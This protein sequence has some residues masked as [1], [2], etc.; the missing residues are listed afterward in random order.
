MK[1]SRSFFFTLTL[2]TILRLIPINPINIPC[3]YLGHASAQELSGLTLGGYATMSATLHDRSDITPV[4]D[5]SQN[6]DDPFNTHFTAFMDSRLGLQAHYRFNTDLDIVFQ[7]VLRDQAY[8]TPK[9]SM[10][11][12]YAAF[13]PTP[14][15]EFRA[16]RIGYDAFLMSDT[17]NLGYAYTWVRP[18]VE[19]YGWIPIFNMDGADATFRFDWANSN[20][21]LRFQA[22]ENSF[23]FIIADTEYDS[24]TRGLHT[25]TLG[26]QSG[27]LL[28]KAGYSRFSLRNEL[29]VFGP[30]QEGLDAI[31]QGTADP[32]PDISDE[33]RSLSQDLRLKNV[34][35]TYV[36]LG[37]SYDN[38]EW[39]AQTELARTTT[40]AEVL[41][42]GTMGYAALG[43][44]IGDF[45]PY[46]MFS[47]IRSENNLRQPAS[48]WSIIG[49]SELQDI[50]NLIIN[51]TRM[52]QETISLGI[53]WNFHIQAALKFQMD[54]IHMHPFGHGLFFSKT[55]TIYDESHL[56]LGTISLEIVF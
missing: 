15:M 49:E 35:M 37:A 36:T 26:R 47:A 3:L 44:Y 54:N 42:H 18:P 12:G 16:G 23:P 5:I 41:S 11:L 6:F 17:R 25:V 14:W 38:G 45:I 10:E 48:D 51:T 39:I 7:G 55:S 1:R 53:R 19:F 56:S 34:E 52:N 21:R 33:A 8:I 28:I 32:F 22:G 31:A 2:L 50:A 29:S 20:W 43:Y 13:R 9:N 46:I 24:E 30:L 4:R 40:S 27:P